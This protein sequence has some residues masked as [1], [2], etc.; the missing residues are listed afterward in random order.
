MG[1]LWPEI[2]VGGLAGFL[3]GFLGAVAERTMFSARESWKQ[4]RE[5][6]RFVVHK[7]QE[8]AG[9]EKIRCP[10]C[11]SAKASPTGSTVGVRRHPTTGTPMHR[12]HVGFYRCGECGE[13]WSEVLGTEPLEPEGDEGG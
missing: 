4:A 6:V 9:R 2:V 8:V 5:S 3:A 7:L 10:E 13:D 11:L 12:E 1:D